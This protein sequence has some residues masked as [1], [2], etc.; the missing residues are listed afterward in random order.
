MSVVTL[1]AGT[2]AYFEHIRIKV[3]A[4]KMDEGSCV[5][6]QGGATLVSVYRDDQD[7]RVDEPVAKGCAQCAPTDNY[8][9]RIG[10]DIALGR[11]LKA[12]RSSTTAS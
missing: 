12:L 10:R 1:P 5:S 6:P 11:A 7:P 3:K 2:K 4:T 8:N 9:K